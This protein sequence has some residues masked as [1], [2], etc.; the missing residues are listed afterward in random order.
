MLKTSFIKAEDNNPDYG[1]KKIQ[2]KNQDKKEPI[3]K[4]RKIVI[5]QKTIKFKK[6]I[7]VKKAKA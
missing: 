2:V 7:Q 5:D 6:W 1:S 4:N 3:L